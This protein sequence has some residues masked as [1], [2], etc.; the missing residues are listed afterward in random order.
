MEF[1]VMEVIRN[2][3]RKESQF[4][5]L[6]EKEKLEHHLQSDGCKKLLADFPECAKY[7]VTN[8]ASH[9]GIA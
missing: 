8:R 2:Q 7:K 1:E 5:T 4:R 3:S 9:L 6:S